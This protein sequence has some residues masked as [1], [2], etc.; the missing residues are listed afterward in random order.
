LFN[1]NQFIRGFTGDIIVILLIY[2]FIKAFFAFKPSHLAVFTL[3]LAFITEFMQYLRLIN[4]LGLGENLAARLIIGS[5]FDPFDLIAY[6]IGAIAV[7][8]ID[9]KLIGHL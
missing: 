3:G 9:T 4:L 6:T 5:V 7:Y 2:F 8:I 1:N